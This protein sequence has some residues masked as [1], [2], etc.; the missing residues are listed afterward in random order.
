MTQPRKLADGLF[1]LETTV[2]GT[3]MPLAIHLVDGDDWLVTDTGCIGMMRDL[4]LPAVDGLRSGSR[5]GRA[6]ISH[7]HADHFGG[8][9]E[10]VDADPACRLLVHELDADWA[11]E[12]SWHVRDAYGAL[13]R[14]YPCP[15]DVQAWVAGLLGRPTPV[16]PLRT[17]EWL[18]L[19]D[20][21]GLRVIHLPGHSPGHIGL[22]E[23]EERWLILADAILGDG[24][25]VAGRVVG[26]PAYLDVDAYLGSIRTVRALAPDVCCPAHFPVM[27]GE[28]TQ[29]FCDLSEAFV[30]RLD[31][32]V[33]TCLSEHDGVTLRR[34]TAEVVPKVAPG[35]EA[36]MVAALSVQAHLDAWARRG[37][38]HWEMDGDE[39]VWRST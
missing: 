16:T 25:K 10:L 19:P 33:R 38:A 7:A 9:A 11:R 37:G 26:I 39:R 27:D 28:A 36:S 15:P 3:D 2:T 32:A 4:A 22:W 14:D 31:D 21:H 30:Q 5:I 6:V 29:A 17:G 23:P 1:R 20:G 34:L 8:N 24:Q 35:V 13:G 18:D 12:P